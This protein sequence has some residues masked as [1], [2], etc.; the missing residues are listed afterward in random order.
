MAEGGNLEGE[1]VCLDEDDAEVGADGIGLREEVLNLGR[2][3]GGGNIVVLGLNAE[4]G[5]SDAATGEVGGMASVDEAH[6][7]GLGGCFE[8]GHAVI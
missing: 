1:A 2:G 8:I 4:Q 5:V 3:G 7:G 6:G